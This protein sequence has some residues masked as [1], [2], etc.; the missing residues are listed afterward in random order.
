MYAVIFYSQ[1]NED[2]EGY[3][4]VRDRMLELVSQQPGYISHE[5][6]MNDDGRGVTISYWDSIES[7][8][9]WKNNQ[10]HSEARQKGRELWYK[11]YKVE[12]A[13]IENSYSYPN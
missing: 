7:L 6:F 9:G 4:E 2:L 13:K 11:N 10:E 3:S 8:Q 12:I 5:S 1:K